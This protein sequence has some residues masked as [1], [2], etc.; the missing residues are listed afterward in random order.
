MINELA[1]CLHI[2]LVDALR[3]GYRRAKINGELLEQENY[4]C[5]RHLFKYCGL[6]IKIDSSIWQA[7]R[8]VYL[9]EAMDEEDRQYFV[10][11]EG[12]G[13]TECGQAWV[14]Q[15]FLISDSRLEGNT[16]QPD[17]IHEKIESLIDKYRFRDVDSTYQRN[18]GVFN[19]QPKIYDWG[20]N[21]YDE[22]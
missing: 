11:L 4:R 21:K 14:A 19:G 17:W 3:G 8:E 7:A 10:S 5:N 12:N 13:E 1:K 18:W 20:L 22:S 6:L 15:R 9:W 16:P 2:E